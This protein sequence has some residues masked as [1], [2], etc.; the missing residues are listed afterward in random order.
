[1]DIWSFQTGIYNNGND[2]VELEFKI[3]SS[4]SSFAGPFGSYSITWQGNLDK[5][6][7]SFTNGM[8][9]YNHIDIIEETVGELV[10]T[11]IPER[12]N[13]RYIS[14]STTPKNG[15][16]SSPYILAVDNIGVS[17]NGQI[18]TCGVVENG[19]ATLKVWL[20]S[21]RHKYS[22]DKT[23]SVKLDIRVHSESTFN[24]SSY[25]YNIIREGI[26]VDFTNG[27]AVFLY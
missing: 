23:E 14:V 9:I 7:V 17:N 16:L 12:Y 15:F 2:S 3:S 13:G 27:K 4:G 24:L 18:V 21:N 22:Y 25:S 6:I 1:M 19:S 26:T 11:N 8:A 5:S 10:I 20:R